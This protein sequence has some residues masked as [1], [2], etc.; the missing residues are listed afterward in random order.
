MYTEP[1]RRVMKRRQLLVAAPHTTV[2][3]ASMMMASRHVGAILV[4]EGHQLL[5]IFTERDAVFRV[6]ACGLE[7]D[8]TPL[9]A[10][11]TAAPHTVSSGQS[12]GYGMLV[13]Q[14]HGFRHLPVVDD[15][16]LVGIVSSRN[17]LDPDLDEFN[18]E[19]RRRAHL[20]HA[21]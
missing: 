18:F 10:V 16:K 8:A 20:Q 7:P 1:I 17:A 11:M 13:M 2:R 3:K 5:G 14:Q 21:G 19:A 12:F 9:A 6:V 15:G 4:V